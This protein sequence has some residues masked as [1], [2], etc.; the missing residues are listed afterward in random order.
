M[1][2]TCVTELVELFKQMDIAAQ[3]K[4]ASLPNFIK[5]FHLACIAVQARKNNG[6]INLPPGSNM[7]SYASRMGLWEAIGK[8][9][10]VNVN[11]RV[12]GGRLIEAKAITKDEDVHAVSIEISDMFKQTGTDDESCEALQIL[13]AE[14]LGNCCAHSSNDEE[15][16]GMVTGQLWKRGKLAQICIV[17]CGKGIRASLG[18]NSQLQGRLL[19]ENA[20]QIATEYGVTGKPNGTHSGYGL[21]L[22]ND[23]IKQNRGGLIIVS[24]NECYINQYG[25]INSK[26]LHIP[27]DGTLIVFEW[28]TDIPLDVNSVYDSWPMSESLKEDQYADLFD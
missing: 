24:G 21:T 2:K 3:G 9:P 20:C 4:E 1:E 8:V 6:D 18:N 26:T 27:W 13:A 22:T 10:P 19:S 17:D 23:L 14:L 25:V 12:N 15:I 16:F 11:R 5:P 28:N 7:E